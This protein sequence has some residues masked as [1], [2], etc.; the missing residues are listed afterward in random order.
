M[1]GR[2]PDSPRWSERKGHLGCR[3]AG[4]SLGARPRPCRVDAPVVFLRRR[5]TARPSHSAGRDLNGDG[6]ADLVWALDGT[7]SL[8]ALSGKDGSLLWTYCVHHVT[9]SS[10]LSEKDLPAGRTLGVPS[11]ADIDGDGLPDLVAG[12]A[13]VDAPAR[14]NALPA[15][16]AQGGLVDKVG[17]AD[18]CVIAAVSGRSG[19]ALWT[20]AAGS[21]G[22]PLEPAA[23]DRGA[24]ILRG[25]G[26]PLRGTGQ[27]AL[28]PCRFEDRPPPLGPP[29]DFGFEPTR[30]L[31]YADLD[32][33]GDPEILATGE[34]TGGGRFSLAAFAPL[35]GSALADARLGPLHLLRTQRGSLDSHLATARRPGRGWTR[36]DRDPDF[37]PEDKYSGMR[38]DAVTGKTRWKRPM[39][40]YPGYFDGLIHLLEGPDLDGDGTKD[41]VV[42][43]RVDSRAWESS[44]SDTSPG[45]PAE[46]SW[47]YVNA[48]SG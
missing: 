41:V 38:L 24:A 6:I 29:I 4:S 13:L 8:L 40:P 32:G 28:G 25:K 7:P 36:R 19:K 43:W 26:R 30:P 15:R 27:L 37:D 45:R 39:T 11:L 5:K 21:D 31:Q 44:G 17:V 33:D 18:T 46:K 2:N 22:M 10:L 12:F 3:T 35:T 42:V 47:L 23:S 1:D 9:S 20:Q 34:R 48:L 14:V 16:G